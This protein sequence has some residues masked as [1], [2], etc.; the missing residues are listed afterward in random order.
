MIMS[1]KIRFY[2]KKRGLSQQ[3][4]ADKLNVVRQTVSKWEQ[5]LSVPDSQMLV[6]LARELGISEG[7]SKSNLARAKEILKRKIKAYLSD[8]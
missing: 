8:E 7:T 3:E 6:A 4:L 5:G 1:E 2:R